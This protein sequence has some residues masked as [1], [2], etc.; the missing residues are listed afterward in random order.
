MRSVEA[1]HD[2]LAGSSGDPGE[3]AD[4]A[5]EGVDLDLARPC[6]APQ[7]GVLRLLDTALAN[8][9]IR[10]LEQR[11]PGQLRL[12]NRGDIADDV[13]RGLAERIGSA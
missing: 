10:Q 12:G 3:L 1:A 11:I 8:A 13:R 9:K 5:A 6:T 2:V 4:D 7:F